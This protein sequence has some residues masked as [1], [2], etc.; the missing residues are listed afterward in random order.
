MNSVTE[1]Y[2]TL[3]NDLQKLMDDVNESKIVNIKVGKYPHVEDFRAHSNILM[4]RSPYF[5]DKLSRQAIIDSVDEN[6]MIV[7]VIQE[8]DAESFPIILRYIHTGV[9]DLSTF[10]AQGLLNMLVSANILQ[11]EELTYHLQDYLINKYSNWIQQNYVQV[12]SKIPENQDNFSK[13]LLY[14][15]EKIGE[16]PM[17]LFSLNEFTELDNEMFYTILEQETLQ[18][19]EVN[20]WEAL[21]KWCLAQSPI[22]KSKSDDIFNTTKWNEEEFATLKKIIDKF[23]PSIHF[24]EISSSDFY[25]KIRPYRKILS[26]DTFE[27]ILAYHMK[28][29]KRKSIKLWPRLSKIDSEIIKSKQATSIS[30]LI[31]NHYSSQNKKISFSLLYRASRDGFNPGIFR[32]QCNDQGASLAIIK[33]NGGKVIGGYNP[34]GWMKFD[35]KDKNDYSKSFLFSFDSNLDIRSVKSVSVKNPN[36]AFNNQ[37]QHALHFGTSDLIINGKTGTCTVKDFQN[38]IVNNQNFNVEN[39]EVFAVR[40]K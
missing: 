22:L 24:F 15:F 13:I 27:E 40:M 33:I 4:V 8:I 28:E 31:G 3:S 39:I 7:D 29:S 17:S 5:K 23:I 9:A 1:F 36:S 32:N 37:N 35:P 16:N 34:L 20:I 18:C 26:P 14:C 6:N 2:R 38:P 10:D 19:E 30:N 21:I 12:L 11:L 25:S